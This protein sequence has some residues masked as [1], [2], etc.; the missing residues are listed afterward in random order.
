MKAGPFSGTE[1][2]GSISVTIQEFDA[3]RSTP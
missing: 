3:L 1:I 2:T